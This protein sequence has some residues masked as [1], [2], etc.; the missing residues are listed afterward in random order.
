MLPGTPRVCSPAL[1][2]EN[3]EQWLP[4]GEVQSRLLWSTDGGTRR[5]TPFCAP[6]PTSASLFGFEVG[7]CV[8]VDKEKK[9]GLAEIFHV[10]RRK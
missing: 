5:M 8:M 6:G 2:R 1:E 10:G 4:L 9:L 3:G 7:L